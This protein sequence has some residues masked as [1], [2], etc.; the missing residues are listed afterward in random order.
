[1]PARAGF[2]PPRGEMIDIGGR[3]RRRVRA[4][5]RSD[6]PVVV[7]ECGAF[8]CAADWA[9]VQERLARRGLYSLAYDRAGLGYS[10]PGPVPRDGRAIAADLEALLA[11]AGETGPLVMVGHSMGGLL[12]RVFV[13]RNR[14]RVKGVVL[15]DAVTPETIEA[16]A[17]ARAIHAYRRAMKLLGRWAG[18]GFMRPVALLMGDMIGL[19]GEAS[20]EKRRIYGLA[21]HAR[22]SAEEVSQWPETSLQGREIGPYDPAVPVAVVTAGATR[23][24]AHLKVVQAA[25][26]RESRHGRATE[27]AGA[28]HASL[29]GKR[30]AD[31]IIDGIDHVLDAL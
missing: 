11:H 30:F 28:G 25:P 22:W 7:L 31:P 26:A 14:E 19:E 9:V 24:P 6:K 23:L 3:R 8:G 21:S 5:E 4:G 13:G 12:L 10:D 15:V 2:H 17:A 1:M 18:M 16:P 20:A 29:L 27:I